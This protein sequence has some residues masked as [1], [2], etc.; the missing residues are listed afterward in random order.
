MHVQKTFPKTVSQ[1]RAC[2]VLGQPR[3]TQGYNAG[4]S[5]DDE[6][7]IGRDCAAVFFRFPINLFEDVLSEVV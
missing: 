3:S 1:R 5:D 7:N 4:T 2:K 6:A